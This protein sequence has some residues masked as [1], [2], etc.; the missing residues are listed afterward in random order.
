[1][2][3]AMPRENQLFYVRGLVT[4]IVITLLSACSMFGVRSV[5]EAPF[6]VVFEEGDFQ[7][8]QYSNYLVAETTVIADFDQAGNTAF[9]RLFGYISGEN[10]T[11]ENIAMTAPVMSEKQAQVWQYYFVLPQELSLSSA[12]SPSDPTVSIKERS[13]KLVATLQY[14]GLNNETIFEEKVSELNAWILSK[15]LTPVSLPSFAGYDPPWTIPLFRRNEVL[16][17]VKN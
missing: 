17:D 10:K 11:T 2:F 8:R 3:N 5:E 4:L 9:S 1:M 16:I 14:S 15:N 7:L 6:T 12:P 13:S